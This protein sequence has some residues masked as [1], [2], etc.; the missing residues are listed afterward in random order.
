MMM[1]MMDHKVAVAVVLIILIAA[2]LV[3]SASAGIQN[4]MIRYNFNARWWS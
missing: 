2:D 4:L 1:V 3:K